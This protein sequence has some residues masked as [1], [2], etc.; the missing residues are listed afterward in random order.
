MG[1][2]KSKNITKPFNAIELQTNIMIAQA[3]LTQGKNKKAGLINQKIKEIKETLNI[4]SLDIVKAKM[5]SILREEDY[6]SVYDILS[7]LCEILKDR[8][9]YLMYNKTCPNDLRAIIN[10]LIYASTRLELED[11]HKIRELFKQRYGEE[12]IKKANSNAE[13]LVNRVVV[14][15]LKVKPASENLLIVRLKQLCQIEKI[16]FDWPS[17]I[18]PVSSYDIN[19]PYNQSKNFGSNSTN[20]NFTFGNTNYYCERDNKFHTKYNNPNQTSNSKANNIDNINNKNSFSNNMYNNNIS[21]PKENKTNTFNKMHSMDVASEQLHS[22]YSNM[23]PYHNYQSHTQHYSNAP[24][25]FPTQ[26]IINEKGFFKNNKQG[27]MKNKN[28]D[29]EQNDNSEKETCDL[30]SP[31]SSNKDEEKIKFIENTDNHSNE[32]DANQVVISKL[33][34]TKHKSYQPFVD[35]SDFPSADINDF[36]DASKSC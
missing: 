4:N 9:T 28:A 27:G 13:L 10:T 6:I 29:F 19:N 11:S 33:R 36:P 32:D 1:N 12:F 15:K 8:V 14:E 17:E 21:Y 23:N 26:S 7:P 2:R 34:Y 24:E 5:E 16:S 25:E 31:V 30:E 22:D 20:T 35:N 18:E 3:K